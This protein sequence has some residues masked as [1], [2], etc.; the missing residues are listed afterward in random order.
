MD[1]SSIVAA[2]LDDLALVATSQPNERLPKE[3]QIRCCIYA[4]IRP[5]YRVVCA[6]AGMGPSTTRAG[7]SVT[8]GLPLRIRRPPVGVQAVLVREGL[9]Q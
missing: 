2:V 3:E 4:M 1:V 7:S 5:L 9:D 8:S 6:S